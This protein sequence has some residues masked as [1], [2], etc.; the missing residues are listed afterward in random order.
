[1]VGRT[2]AHRGDM[3]TVMSFGGRGT[4]VVR[5]DTEPPAVRFNGGGPVDNG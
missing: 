5:V 1:V 4:T 3:L 2:K